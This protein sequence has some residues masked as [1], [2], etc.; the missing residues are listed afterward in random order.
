MLSEVF[1]RKDIPKKGEK[2]NNL[3]TRIFNT[4]VFRLKIKFPDEILYKK[5]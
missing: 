5:T 1:P 4:N 2:T 3:P